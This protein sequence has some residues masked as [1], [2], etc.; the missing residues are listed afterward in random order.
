MPEEDD[1]F[2][3]ES[4]TLREKLNVD[5]IKQLKYMAAASRGGANSM[6]PAVA[7][8][9]AMP[10]EVI[11]VRHLAVTMEGMQQVANIEVEFAGKLMK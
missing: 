1:S 5:V 8:M 9:P 4:T 3:Q 7:D 6:Y 2:I 11:S 10:P